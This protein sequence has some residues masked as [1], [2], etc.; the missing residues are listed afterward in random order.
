MFAEATQKANLPIS[1][2]IVDCD[3]VDAFCKAEKVTAPKVGRKAAKADA[4]QD[5]RC[6]HDGTGFKPE[7]NGTEYHYAADELLDYLTRKLTGGTGTGLGNSS[8]AD[9]VITIVTE[10]N[11]GWFLN[12]KA[13]VLLHLYTPWSPDVHHDSEILTQFA[14]QVQQQQQRQHQNRNSSDQL[15]ELSI[16][17]LDCLRY[18][19]LCDATGI[20]R[21]IGTNTEISAFRWFQSGIQHIFYDH[22]YGFGFGETRTVEYLKGRSKTMLDRYDKRAKSDTRDQ[23]FVK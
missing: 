5:V 14:Q 16:G 19:K 9:G 10:D 20:R 2:G 21:E 7:L 22:I 8:S 18:K 4:L 12:K 3:Y 13:S 1:I 15:S 11:W 23:L 17:R 6:Y